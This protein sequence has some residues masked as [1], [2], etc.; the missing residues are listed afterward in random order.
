[1]AKAVSYHF[2]LLLEKMYAS[3]R[4]PAFF[5]TKKGMM[6]QHFGCVGHPGDFLGFI[7]LCAESIV[8]DL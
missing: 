4:I 1:M 7:Q 3:C 6:M 8:L 2:R 5:L